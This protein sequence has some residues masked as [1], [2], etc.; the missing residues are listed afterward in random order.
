MDP[1]N[2]LALTAVQPGTFI[3]M[4]RNTTETHAI[5]LGS[6]LVAGKQTM[7]S[8]A[9]SGETYLHLPFDIHYT[10]PNAVPQ[11][12]IT[13]CDSTEVATTEH[14]I[15]AR[16]QVLKRIRELEV[17]IESE[18]NRIG[19]HMT[20]AYHRHRSR[21]N[22]EWAHVTL[23]E[24]AQS[25][26]EG[27][28]NNVITMLAVHKHLMRRSKEFVPSA[29]DFT[30]TQLFWV[31]P[32]QDVQDLEMVDNLL[33]E[34]SPV[35]TDFVNKARKAILR[36]RDIAKDKYA[37]PPTLLPI[38]DLEFTETEQSIL[39][40]LHAFIRSTRS[41]QKDPYIVPVAYLMKKTMYSDPDSPPLELPFGPHN[42][43]TDETV[44]A[45]LVDLGVLARWDEPNT[46]DRQFT[47][48]NQKGTETKL[49]IITTKN[50]VTLRSLGPLD[51]Y[52]RDIVESIRHDFGSMPVY[53]ID[54]V[55]AEELD[56]G[57]S[58]E[59]IPN[60]PGSHWVHVHVADPTSILPPTHIAAQIAQ[61][62]LSTIYLV[63]QSMPMLPSTQ[64]FQKCSLGSSKENK[65]LTFSFKVDPEGEVTSYKVRAGIVR[66]IHV[67]N[68]GSVDAALGLP[69]SDPV[70]PFEP[71]YKV[72]ADPSNVP[73]ECLPGLQT[74]L[75]VTQSLVRA[76]QKTDAFIAFLPHL[77]ITMSKPKPPP[78][79]PGPTNPPQLST[80]FPSLS[81]SIDSSSSFTQLSS[82]MIV[83]EAMKGAC[84]ITSR[85][86]RDRGIPA[87]RRSGAP[88]LVSSPDTLSSLLALRNPFGT[89]PYVEVLKTNSVFP[90]AE[91]TLQPSGHWQLAIPD[92]EGYV[93]VTSPL[94][95]YTDLLTHWQVKYALKNPKEAAPLFDQGWLQD[96]I[97]E[98][99]SKEAQFKRIEQHHIQNW[100]VHFLKRWIEYPD[101]RGDDIVEDPLQSLDAVV[102]GDRRHNTLD[103][104]YQN[105]VFLPKLGLKARMIGMTRMVSPDVGE[106]VKVRLKGLSV[107][108]RPTVTVEKL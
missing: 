76:R 15:A 17:Q 32:Y 72:H 60:E 16:V 30:R 92:G 56:D 13:R 50:E 2:G 48:L 40:F 20:G 37:G 81:Y 35:I 66:N 63:Q 38:P 46:R 45:F 39:C 88:I 69:N 101:I 21:D 36:N 70:R 5:V 19:A 90:A 42:S 78:P 103:N 6:T 83:A 87:I 4:R 59:S 102:L 97:V 43:I 14:Q 73:A 11:D 7:I 25:L 29:A 61:R 9:S 82:R 71:N 10:I 62:Q 91:Y 31:R 84:R 1:E 24:V 94:R 53:V 95:R 64:E 57:L 98:L 26:E 12:L 3:E 47:F 33:H 75:S 105:T 49:P 28:E 52:P 51:L 74:L 18:F 99:Q 86:F 65:T 77:D 104:A 55:G 58:V 22:Q 93:R 85:F 27:A 96:F 106:E 8:L 79:S 23:R 34:K 41:N 54:D 108:L 68:Y 107:G 100:A 80:G 89:V 67:L 44:N